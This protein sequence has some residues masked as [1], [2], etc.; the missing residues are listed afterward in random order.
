MSRPKDLLRQAATGPEADAEWLALKARLQQIETW[1]ALG[2]PREAAFEAS[3]R[4]ERARRMER[5]AR[6]H[7]CLAIAR[8]MMAAKRAA[9][10]VS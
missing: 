7:E 3:V 1:I 6:V 9:A 5:D 10:G 2:V 8:Y 4:C